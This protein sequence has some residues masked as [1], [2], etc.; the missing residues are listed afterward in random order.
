MRLDQ[1]PGFAHLVF[2]SA[3]NL[4]QVLDFL[5]HAVEHLAHGIDFDFTAFEPLQRETDRQVFGELHDHGLVRLGVRRLRRQARER[6][7]QHVLRAA[8][9]LR[10]LLLEHT[11]RSHS[12]LPRAD[13]PKTSQGAENCED[14][15]F[16]RLTVPTGSASFSCT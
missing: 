12:T 7:L 11:C 2:M 4:S 14:L 16:A 15:I 3:E 10:H 13:V 5:V 1:Q 6:L 8:R 9:Q